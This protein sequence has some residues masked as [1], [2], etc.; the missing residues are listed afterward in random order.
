MLVVFIAIAF[1]SGCGMKEGHQEVVKEQRANERIHTE[2]IGD[3]N[4]Y[5][6]FSVID[7]KTGK[8]YITSKDFNLTE[9]SK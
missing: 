1:L 6:V 7:K 9:V 2:R 3:I 4:G 5:H 8:E